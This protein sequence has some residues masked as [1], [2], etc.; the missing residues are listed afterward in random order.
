MHTPGSKM[1][2]AGVLQ[3]HWGRVY[4]TSFSVLW[5]DSLILC[6]GANPVPVL[7]E[8][9]WISAVQIKLE[10]LELLP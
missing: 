8:Q 6:S 10:K 7:E 2:F 9:K 1:N 4:G 5:S 3:Q